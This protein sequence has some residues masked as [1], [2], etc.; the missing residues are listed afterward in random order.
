MVEPLL[1]STDISELQFA[2]IFYLFFKAMSKCVSSILAALI[3][4]QGASQSNANPQHESLIY[5]Y[6]NPY[7]SLSTPNGAAF[8]L[9]FHPYRKVLE[10]EQQEEAILSQ[11]TKDQVGL[12]IYITE[13]RDLGR[14]YIITSYC[15]TST[16]ALSVCTPSGRRKR[17]SK[18]VRG[19]FYE[20]EGLAEQTK[21]EDD[22]NIHLHNIPEEL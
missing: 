19:L 18:G 9:P 5:G 7:S 2:I 11:V 22:S 14:R 13:T 10:R 12:T 4:C 8:H 15:T 21:I 6:N 3:L 1:T 17:F 20:E 16:T